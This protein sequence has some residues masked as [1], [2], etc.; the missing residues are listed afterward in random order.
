MKQHTDWNIL[1][2]LAEA[3]TDLNLR[4]LFG[5]DSRRTSEFSCSAGEFHLDYSKNLVDKE[6]F[7]SLIKFA[8]KRQLKENISNMF[9][10]AIVNPTEK[11]AALHTLLRTPKASTSN[12]KQLENV[13]NTLDRMRALVEVIEQK[14]WK[15]FSGKAITDVVNIGV[16]G[17]DLGPHLAAEALWA[18][19]QNGI[20]SH[21]TSNIDGADVYRTLQELNPETTLFVVSSKSFGTLET[22]TNALYARNWLLEHTSFEQLKNHFIAVT[23]NTEKA[24]EF[25]IDKDNVFPMW[26]WVGGRFSLWSSIGLSIALAAGWQN[27]QKLLDGAHSMDQ[28]FL[29]T[30]LEQ[31][32]PVILAL[33]CAWNCTV[34]GA[35]S[36]GVI[37]YSSALRLL[38]DYLQQLEME[39]N[40]KSVTQDGEPLELQSSPIIWGNT[41]TN[42]QHSFHQLLHQGT[43]KVP[44]DFILPLQS[45]SPLL[46]HHKHLVANCLSQ[47]QVLAFGSDQTQIMQELTSSGMIEAEAAQL[48][49]H[50]TI[51]GN[52][53]HNLIT[54]DKLTPYNLG[55]IIALY[56]H[57]VFCLSVF[58]GINAF[59]QWGVELGKKVSQKLF[60]NLN[61]TSETSPPNQSFTD[62]SSEVIIERFK[63]LNK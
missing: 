6:I 16:G 13:H 4:E 30:P 44:I 43:I 60:A 12:F 48:S 26:D 38:P 47:S 39:S 41:G 51:K 20:K 63:Q 45:N 11:R 7:E 50:Q 18:Y 21:F 37:P 10:G 42:S 25:G 52:K 29:N 8:E 40:G 31:N 56:E 27:F 24:I 49:K 5:N 35:Q 33:L 1:Q 2:K 19:E 28:H 46:D 55:Q 17:S 14:K 3:K 36:Y 22:L 62:S 54:F 58:W 53:P 32:M 59:D 15:G 34:N 9:A 57:K 23:A 61:G